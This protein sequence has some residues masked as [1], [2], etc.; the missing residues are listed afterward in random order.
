MRLPLFLL[1]LALWAAPVA[2]RDGGGTFGA[3]P[4]D[5]TQ[6][7]ERMMALYPDA[8]AGFDGSVLMLK[9]GVQLAL[10]DGR[11]NKTAED[12]LNAPDVGDMF[13]FDYPRGAQ[14]GQPPIDFD[15]GRI[16]VEALF[17]ALYGDCQ[18]EKMWSRMRSIPWVPGHGGGIVSITTENGVDR[19]LE[20]VS[21]ELDTLPK[22]FGKYLKPL[23]GTY[24]CRPIAG[25]SRMS[26]HA[27]GAAID[28]NTKYSAYWRWASPSA[29][30]LIQWTNQIP[31][32]I[33]AIF[34]KH[35]FIWGGRWYHYDTMHFEY[36]PE[37]LSD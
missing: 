32:E 20:A 13:A 15:P 16:R 31:D 14:A 5:L 35:G 9:N 3:N 12:L 6:R 4:P 1:V 24:N 11:T 17:R 36:R 28:L 30:G 34:E 8:I 7:L 37:L 33:V 18:K 19:A 2:A 23:G 29:D 26:M 22:S 10:S 27:Y 21:R 25:T